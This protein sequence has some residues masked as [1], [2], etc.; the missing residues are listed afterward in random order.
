MTAAETP[1]LIPVR[2]TGVTRTHR[3]R[4]L[5]V[6]EH[7]E[8]ETLDGRTIDVARYPAYPYRNGVVTWWEDGVR[9]TEEHSGALS[10]V[11]MVHAA[12]YRLQ[13]P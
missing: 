10:P 9:H 12:G 13:E 11:G 5:G 6:H 4:H 2:R 7:T 3:L 1:D 8:F